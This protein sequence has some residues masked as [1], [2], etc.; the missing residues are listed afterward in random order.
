MGDLIKELFR[1]RLY[2]SNQG[3][4]VRRLTMLGIIAIFASGA[5][6]FFDMAF[7][8][9]AILSSMGAR[10]IIAGLICAAGAWFAFRVVNWPTFADFLISVE[11]EMVKVSWPSKAETYSSTLVVLTM[12][13]LLAALIFLFDM[14]WIQI[15]RHVIPIM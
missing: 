4:L 12:F 8:E 15:F 7:L 10:G 5:Y 3:K 9:V 11:S 14:V 6:K 2:K 13:F 1:V